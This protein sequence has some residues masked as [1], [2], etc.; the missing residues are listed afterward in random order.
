MPNYAPR[1]LAA[2]A[3]T[4]SLALAGCGTPAATPTPTP[5]ATATETATATPT[6]T[7]TPTVTPGPLVN[8]LDG[9][10]VSGAAGAAPTVTVPSMTIDE[11]RSKVVT[12]GAGPVVAAGGLVDVHYLG[13]NGRTGATFDTSWE[14]GASATFPLDQVVPGFAKGLEG[15]RVGDRVLIAMTGA[16]GYDPAGGNEAAGIAVGDTLVFVVDIV[17]TSLATATGTAVAPPADAP[18]VAVVDGLPVVTIPAGAAVPTAT[19]VHPLITGAGRQ[20]GETDY[21]LVKYRSWSWKSGKQLEDKYATADYGN[22]AE[23]IAAWR[24]GIIGKPI[25]SRV[26]IVAAPADSY[27]EGSN[28]PPLDK[29]DTPVYVVDILFASSQPWQ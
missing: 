25:G 24:T 18:A 16:D 9:I 10:Q 26:L 13:V 3:V 4:L 2:A 8:S 22:I 28:N 19:A 29:G 23:T 27:P 17:E 20:V 7:P 12:P 21:V 14:R 11:T 5:S 6:P 15:K 1:L